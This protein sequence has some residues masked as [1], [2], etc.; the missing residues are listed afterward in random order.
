MKDYA[1][2]KDSK[3]T[4]MPD[5]FKIIAPDVDYLFGVDDE[6]E[7]QAWIEEIANL[8]TQLTLNALTKSPP[9]PTRTRQDSA[10]PVPNT[11]AAVMEL[12]T[13][14]GNTT[15]ADCGSTSTSLF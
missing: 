3:A 14:D 15:C 9:P 4:A 6:E 12:G 5:C 8:C 7:C 10:P 1:P 13:L 2:E 11:K